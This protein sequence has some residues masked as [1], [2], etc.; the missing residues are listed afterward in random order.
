MDAKREQA[1]VGLFVIVAAG[2]LL[3]TIFALTGAFSRA[4][5]EYRAYFKFAAG[6]GPGATVRYAGGPQVGRV[7]EVRSDPNNPR[8]ME[9]KFRVRPGTPV[10]TDSVVKIFSLSPLGDNYL[11]IAPGSLGAPAA[12][13]GSELKAADY[14][15]F[16]DVKDVLNQVAPQAQEL[17]KNLNAR[18]L[19]LRETIARVNELLNEQNRANISASLAHVRGML[20]EDRPKVK[21]TLTHLD[22]ASAK[23]GPLLDDFKKT[24]AQANEAISHIDATLMENRPDLRK[25]LVELRDALA[26]AQSLTD[27]LDRRVTA[28]SENIDETLQN[29]RDITENLR[30]FTDTIKTRP[31]TLIRASGPPPRQPGELPKK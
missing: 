21:S 8:R 17:L 7:E 19:E 30:E 26:S 2:L 6:L 9:I 5:P 18:V 29:I 4:G 11:E 23:V 25:S 10:K 27:Q 31:Y 24:V 1:A 28:N 12:P 15:S 13:S 14:A 16:E 22:D 3:A 20:E